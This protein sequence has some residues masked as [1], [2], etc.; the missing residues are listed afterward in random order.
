MRQ[1]DLAR[2]GDRP[3]SHQARI[4]DGMVW[5]GARNGR[6]TISEP[7][8]GTRPATE[9]IFVT[10]M[11]SATVR[12]GMMPGSLRASM[13]FTDPGGPSRSRLC[14]PAAAISNALSKFLPLHVG[15]ISCGRSSL[16]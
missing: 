12:E 9:W 16:S 11:D 8:A 7:P 2:P 13:V 15:E 5:C 3:S 6:P 4:T 1:T 10:S 14:A